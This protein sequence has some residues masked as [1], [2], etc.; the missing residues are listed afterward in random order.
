MPHLHKRT[1]RYVHMYAHAAAQSF[2][3]STTYALQIMHGGH[4]LHY[5]LSICLLHECICS[6]VLVQQAGIRGRTRW[7]QGMLRRASSSTTPMMMTSSTAECSRKSICSGTGI[8][9]TASSL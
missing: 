5:L 8:I 1:F 7:R 3:C 2:C 6:Y 9:V 4:R